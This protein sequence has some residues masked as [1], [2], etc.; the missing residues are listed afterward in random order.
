MVNE[1]LRT[2]PNRLWLLAFGPQRPHAL[3]HNRRDSIVLT[4]K[5]PTTAQH[6][7]VSR[8]GGSDDPD[9]SGAIDAHVILC[10]GGERVGQVP[11][12]KDD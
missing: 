6:S 12:E 2:R 9:E 10:Q 7:Q 1:G 11:K 3:Q 4:V 8:Y 5:V